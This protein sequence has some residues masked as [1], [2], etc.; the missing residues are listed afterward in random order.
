MPEETKRPSSES[1]ILQQLFYLSRLI[2]HSKIRQEIFSVVKEKFK[3][4]DSVTFDVDL[5][6]TFEIPRAMYE[7]INGLYAQDVIKECCKMGIGVPIDPNYD[8]PLDLP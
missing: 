1:W 8:K 6:F 3:G 4:Q 5:R 7:T 2:P